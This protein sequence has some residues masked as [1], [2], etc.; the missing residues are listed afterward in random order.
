MP[1]T[2]VREALKCI[3]IVQQF[4]HITI[5]FPSIFFYKF[6]YSCVFLFSKEYIILLCKTTSL[7]LYQNY[8]VWEFK[9]FHLTLERGLLG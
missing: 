1:D 4:S 8:F 9:I 5:T 3:L 6:D 2:N 7:D